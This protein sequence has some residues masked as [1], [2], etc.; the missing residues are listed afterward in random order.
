MMGTDGGMAIDLDELDE[1]LK[2]PD[3]LPVAQSLEAVG[4][5]SA[6]DLLST[7]AGRRVDLAPWLAGAEVNRDRKPWLQY[8]AG[9]ESY[10]AQKADVYR[11]MAVYRRFP[12]DLFVGSGALKQEL[13][14]GGGS[15]KVDP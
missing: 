13:R 10:T 2:R 12:E 3:Y 15:Q 8:Q 11:A 1:R 6:I 5:R 9:L 7:Y 14:A 4:F